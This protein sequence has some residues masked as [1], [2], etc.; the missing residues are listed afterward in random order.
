MSI[1]PTWG[2]LDDVVMGGVSESSLQI[3]I[4]GGE[5]GRATGCFKGLLNFDIMF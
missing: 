1:G 3:S 2:A 5:D 4:S